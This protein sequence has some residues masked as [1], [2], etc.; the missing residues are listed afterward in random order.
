MNTP[1]KLLVIEDVLADFLLLERHL[2]RELPGA[3]CIRVDNDAAL[4]VA[5]R[6]QWHVVLSDYQVP[7]MDFRTTLQRIRTHSPDLPVI[8]VS[9]SVGEET[10]VDLL[11][12]GLADFVRK[13]HL[14][15]LPAAIGRALDEVGE[16]RSRLAAEAALRESQAAALETQRRAR[17]A[18]LNM[19]EDALATRTALS[20]SETK[21][22]LLA[23]NSVD[24]IFWVD[25]T[26]RYKYVSPACLAISGYPPE[27]FLAD[28]ELMTRLI[29]SDDRAAYR[30]H[31]TEIACP[32]R[33]E[34]EFRLVAKSGELR[35]IAHHCQI[36]YGDDGQ[37]LG[38][39]G[40]NRDITTRKLAELALRQ[41][42]GR[43]RTLV[44]TIPDLVWL[45]SPAGVYLACNPRFER[46]F[47]AAESAIVG[48]TDYDF[49]STELAELARDRDRAAIAANSPQVTEEEVT[50]P[51]GHRE[52]LETIKT[53]MRDS[54]GELIGVLAIA[55]DITAV[56]RTEAQLHKLSL[57]VE[58]S[59]ESIA[60]TDL[61]ARIEY[62]NEAFMR[63]SG[64]SRE[65]L[66]GQNPSMLR[67]GRTPPETYA[68]LWHA[69]S[70]GRTW[71]GEFINRRKDGSDYVEFAIITPIRQ[72]DGR[73]THYVAVQEDITEK[74]RLG[75]EL[76]R[77]RHHLEELVASRTAELEAARSQADAANEAKST[78]LA[79]MSHEIR[80]P[81][82]AIIGLTHLLKRAAPRTEQLD[83]LDK[84]DAAALHLLSIINDILDLSKIEAGRMR[85]E[86]TDFALEPILDHVRSLIGSQAAARGLTVTVD[87]DSVPRWLHGDPTR[88]RQALLNYAGN[89][90]KFTERGG[91][92]LRARVLEE[93]DNELMVRFEVEDTGIGIDPAV[94]PM[95]FEVFQQAD[96]STTREYG[97]T[98]LGLSI[99]RRLAR[100][101]GGEAGVDS[102]PGK[103]STFWFT[104]RLG[105]GHGIMP[106]AR[107]E[108]AL[109]AETELLRG[110]AGSRLLLAEDNEI[111]REVALELLHAVGLTVDVAKDGREALERAGRTHYDLILMDIQMPELDGA[112]ATLA[113]R[114]L[115]GYAAVPVLAMTANVF[116]EDRRMCLA[117]GMNDFI[118]KPVD[119]QLLY[120]TL[121]K[122]LPR[123]RGMDAPAS[124]VAGEGE[125]E[126][127]RRLAAI[128][129]LDAQ[130]GLAIVRNRMDKYL[131]VL[132]LFVEGHHD[133]PQR[134]RQMAAAGDL[135]A[136]QQ[137]A[138]ALKGSAGNIGAL[139]V[140]EAAVTLLSAT[141]EAGEAAAAGGHALRLADELSVLVAAIRDQGAV[142]GAAPKVAE[143]A[144][145]AAVLARLMELLRTGDIAANELARQEEELLRAV[146]GNDGPAILRRIARFDYEGAL[147]LLQAG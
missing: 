125:G 59:P 111:N 80:T 66:I 64:Y 99:T 114:E 104:A 47:G 83:K 82:N 18:A 119:P 84:I 128:A 13:D 7:G 110:Q 78:F 34:L 103:G 26:G 131:R 52:L 6:S 102:E 70:S 11:R 118:A 25:A 77:H 49:I 9:G 39:R 15:R 96:A 32:D 56:R 122:W 109:D 133:D 126:L 65:E 91:I 44:E 42:E 101:M 46:L 123:D 37:Y 40:T 121:L 68:E 113:I 19:M 93:L 94:L 134:L 71:K 106:A 3:E 60:I 43:L 24:W 31:L 88:L 136:L 4:D 33:T 45:K 72:A 5:L 74:K 140:H 144:R 20:E 62:V 132:R 100:I 120:A 2:H 28:H 58:Q 117:A 98:G 1:L 57:A 137:L 107:S 141:R 90:V 95:L 108:I 16:R 12:L 73:I 27:D 8:L 145:A 50:Y 115:P 87:A 112:S 143:R 89:A 135:A 29:R 63:N 147:A 14:V 76:D 124:E 97:G 79:N 81:M 41:S 61:A 38:R 55:R 22:R 21:Y 142:A 105:R 53:P 146:L 92:T 30:Q 48:K 86:Q 54:R 129:G 85:L 69:M 10:A 23:E 139:V 116:E 75:A 130:R 17:L 36:L 67:S 51:D 127:R 138:H 35:W